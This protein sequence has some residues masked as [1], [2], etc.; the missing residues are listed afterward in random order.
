M[1]RN[2][3]CWC[4][5]GK[6]Y[7]KCHMDFDE[8]LNAMKF[9]VFKGQVRPPKKIINNEADIEGIRQSGIIN[10]GALDLMTDMV[11]PGVDTEMLNLAAHNYIIEHGGIPAFLNF[12]NSIVLR[13]PRQNQKQGKNTFINYFFKCTNVKK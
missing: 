3:L 7:K 13:R 4:G 2:D 9:N 6:K 10:D 11:K 5:S 1:T 12:A 8:R